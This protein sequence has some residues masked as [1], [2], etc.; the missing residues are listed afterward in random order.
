MP[1][2]HVTQF[3][4]EATVPDETGQPLDLDCLYGLYT[5]WCLLHRI[6]PLEDLHFREALQR[7]GVE[8][9][10]IHRRITGTAAVDYILASYPAS[11]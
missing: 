10:H 5:S 2:S 9:G 7:R 4:Q 1:T 3:L 11:T 8:T 6:N